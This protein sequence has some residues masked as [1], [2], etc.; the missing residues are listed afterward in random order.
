MTKLR[1]TNIANW[2]VS[3]GL[4]QEIEDKGKNKKIPTKA[5]EDMGLFIETRLGYTG[6]YYIV[7][8][9]KQM[10]EFI[11]DNFDNLIEFLNK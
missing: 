6:E 3:M 11:I 9:P 2:L 7:Q 8:Y 10:Q 1:G 5:G 4:L